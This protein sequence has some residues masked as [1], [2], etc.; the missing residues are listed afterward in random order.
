MAVTIEIYA[1]E[2]SFTSFP[3]TKFDTASPMIRFF[4]FLFDTVFLLLMGYFPALLIL[5]L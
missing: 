3:I 2:K 4:F 5:R 1:Q